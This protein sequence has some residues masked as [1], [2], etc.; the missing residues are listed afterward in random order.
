MKETL[1]DLKTRR[2]CRKY[3]AEQITKEELEQILEAGT[4]APTGTVS[5]THLSQIYQYIKERVYKSKW[6]KRKHYLLMRGLQNWRT[7]CV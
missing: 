3:K 5:Y 6:K 4:Y 7:R 2:S 1:Q